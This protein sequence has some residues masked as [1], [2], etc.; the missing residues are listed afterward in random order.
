[1]NIEIRHQDIRRGVPNG[2]FHLLLC[3]NMVFTYFDEKLQCE[4]G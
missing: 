3:R 2:L 4:T 1:M